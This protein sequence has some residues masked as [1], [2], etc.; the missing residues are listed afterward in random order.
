MAMAI[1]TLLK[2][3]FSRLQI[4]ACNTEK[5]YDMV[6]TRSAMTGYGDAVRFSPPR[7]GQAAFLD[8]LSDFFHG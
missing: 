4:F 6:C 8:L 5:L 2:E 3:K 1:H 7:H